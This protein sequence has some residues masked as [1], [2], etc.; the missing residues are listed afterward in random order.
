MITNT[1]KN[2]LII[3]AAMS[4]PA[5]LKWLYNRIKK[6]INKENNYFIMKHI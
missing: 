4:K 2:I 5:G 1:Q 6:N 3:K